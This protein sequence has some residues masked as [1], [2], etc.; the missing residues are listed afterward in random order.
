MRSVE[1]IGVASGRGDPYQLSPAAETKSQPDLSGAPGACCIVP[2]RAPGSPAP[3]SAPVQRFS[4]RRE[5]NVGHE[6]QAD[7]ATVVR[8]DP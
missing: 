2:L 8:L 4:R 1:N 7:S 5:L 6:G 3:E